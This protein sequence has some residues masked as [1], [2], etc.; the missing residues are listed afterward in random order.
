MLQSFLETVRLLPKSVNC[1]E[2]SSDHPRVQVASAV[3][4]FSTLK[5]IKTFNRSTMLSSRLSSLAMISIESATARKLNYR[6]A[7]GTIRGKEGETEKVFLRH[8]ARVSMRCIVATYFVDL[9][10]SVVGERAWL[11]RLDVRSFSFVLVCSVFFVV[12]GIII[13]A[14]TFDPYHRNLINLPMSLS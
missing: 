14:Y 1:T 5:L 2:D 9:A 13:I 4:S 12:I 8:E 6:R 3:R 10:V 11:K 7:I